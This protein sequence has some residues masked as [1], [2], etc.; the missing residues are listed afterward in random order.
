MSS[1]VTMS[2]E[3][4][5]AIVSMP[6][7]PPLCFSMMAFMNLISSGSRPFLSISRSARAA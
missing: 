1:I 7:G 4:V 5:E 6:T 3:I 2:S